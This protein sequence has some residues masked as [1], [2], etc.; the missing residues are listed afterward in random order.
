MVDKN[1]WILLIIILLFLCFNFFFIIIKVFVLWEII[2]WI[3][4][5]VCV[6]I[7]ELVDIKVIIGVLFLINEIVLCFNLF[8]VKFFVWI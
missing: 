1:G 3:F 4:L 8:V 5:W 2:F 7:V 6:V